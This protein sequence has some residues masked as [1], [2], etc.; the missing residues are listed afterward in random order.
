MSESGLPNWAQATACIS[1]RSALAALATHP[2]DPSAP[3][4]VINGLINTI[5]FQQEAA[6]NN[7]ALL[8]TALQA[9]E[10]LMQDLTQRLAKAEGAVNL[11]RLKGFEDNNG[12]V[13][14][15]IPVG[16]GLEVVP[17]WIQKRNDGKVGLQA[18]KDEEE[19]MYITKLYANPD[20]LGDCPICAMA[21]W[22]K[23]LLGAS[24]GDNH[25]MCT[26]L[27]DLD[28]W[29]LQAN[30]SVINTTLMPAPGSMPR[31]KSW[32]PKTPFTTK[33]WWLAC[34]IWR[35]LGS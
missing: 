7:I 29:G 13:N 6:H 25:H 22:L 15:L 1:P 31:C 14:S 34:T 21:P 19:P 32:R 8:H 3:Q 12:Q 33:S 16:G 23:V 30:T 17:K 2:D 27:L 20:Y 5:H 10:A 26:A 11:A 4:E 35:L 28:E 9:Q 18:G 24:D